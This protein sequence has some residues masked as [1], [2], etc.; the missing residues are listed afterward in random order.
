VFFTR[1]SLVRG[2]E[3]RIIKSNERENGEMVGRSTYRDSGGGGE[4]AGARPVLSQLEIPFPLDLA[5]NLT[6]NGAN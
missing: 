4:G 1:G 5:D 2:L 3:P 6:A